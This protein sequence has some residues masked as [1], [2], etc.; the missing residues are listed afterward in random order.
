MTQ[1][2]VL[3]YLYSKKKN[4]RKF[5]LIQKNYNYFKS[6]LENLLFL[7]FGANKLNEISNSQ[8]IVETVNQ[9]KFIF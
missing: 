6:R 5:N 8:E 7:F 9:N 1:I 2:F 3:F 4:M